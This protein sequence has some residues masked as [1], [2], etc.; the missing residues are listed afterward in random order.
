MLCMTYIMLLIKHSILVQF[1]ISLNWHLQNYQTKATRCLNFMWVSYRPHSGLSKSKDQKNVKLDFLL[2]KR[3]I[4]VRFEKSWNWHSQNPQTK[5]T[6]CLNFMWISYRPHSGLSKIKTDFCL[7]LGSFI[8]ERPLCGRYETHIKL[9]HIVS[10]VRGFC[11]CQFHDFSNLT[12]IERFIS[13]KIQL[14]IFLVLTFWETTV[15]SVLD[16]HII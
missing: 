9:R 16:S 5:L 15:W 8:F 12:K 1:E 6:I 3:S 7:F 4:L 11:K 13:K 2:I 10:F 14:Y